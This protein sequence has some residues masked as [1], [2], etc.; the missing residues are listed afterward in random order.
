MVKKKMIYLQIFTIT[1]TVACL[2]GGSV[3]TPV[4]AQEVPERNNGWYLGVSGAVTNRQ[5]VT[6]ANDSRTTLT[7]NTGLNLNAF[8]GYRIRDFKIEGETSYFNNPIDEATAFTGVVVGGGPA[9]GNVSLFTYMLNV[10]YDIPLKYKLKPYVGGGIGFYQSR[11]DGLRPG[12][13]KDGPS[14]GAPPPDI[15][16]GDIEAGGLNGTSDLPFA[17]QL[18]AGVNYL[19]SE[20]TDV[21]L[22][23]HYF[24]GNE[25]EFN[26]ALPI[27]TTFPDGASIHA[28][29]IGFR[30][31]L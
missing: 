20:K 26:V 19:V 16:Q 3:W 15:T 13:F 8:I 2:V 21:Y 6:E 22:G 10:F 30:V 12:F 4:F 29:E 5:K 28:I 31:S 9:R 18:R 25:L 1:L 11:L 23:Y 24:H 17:Y 7:F 14:V 27:A